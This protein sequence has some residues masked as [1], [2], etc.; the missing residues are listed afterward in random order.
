[1]NP[2]SPMEARAGVEPAS[3]DLQS[4][5]AQR[6]Q[7]ARSTWNSA[8]PGHGVLRSRRVRQLFP[9]LLLAPLLA[10]AQPIYAPSDGKT[11]PT[12]L[13]GGDV[14]FFCGYVHEGKRFWRLHPRARLAANYGG[15]CPPKAEVRPQDIENMKFA[16]PYK[17]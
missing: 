6:A 17:P 12:F 10:I 13:E 14:W 15:K 4:R 5:H 8:H 7:G 3:T 16:L 2:I 9:H 1:M 11:H